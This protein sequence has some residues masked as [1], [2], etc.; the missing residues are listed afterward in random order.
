MNCYSDR[1]ACLIFFLIL[2]CSA[3]TFAQDTTCKAKL[4]AN[5][6][7]SV[8]CNYL[9]I[10][11]NVGGLYKSI[12]GQA[13]NAICYYSMDAQTSHYNR[14]QK[15]EIASQF[16]GAIITSIT[17]PLQRPGLVQYKNEHGD[18]LIDS[19]GPEKI[20]GSYSDLFGAYGW[21]GIVWTKNI[22][23]HTIIYYYSKSSKNSTA[24]DC[25][26]SLLI[27]YHFDGT[28]A[29]RKW[30]STYNAVKPFK[31]ET[32][33][34]LGRISSLATHDSTLLYK[35]GVLQ[36]FGKDTF[37]LQNYLVHE[38]KEYYPTG[39]LKS[40]KYLQSYWNGSN[41]K[42]DT[43]QCLTWRFYNEDGTL[44]KEEKQQYPLVGI[45]IPTEEASAPPD[46]IFLS[47][48]QECAFPGGKKAL[49]R[50]VT[51]NCK[52]ALCNS[53]Q[54]IGGIYT[55][56]L[57]IDKTGYP[58]LISI[59]GL[60]S[61]TISDGVL[62]KMPQWQPSKFNGQPTISTV[63]IKIAIEKNKVTK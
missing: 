9:G 11:K 4:S 53:T 50:F 18:D 27:Q 61:K 22:T 60:N 15:I 3:F 30:F 43:F 34:S 16:D 51:D 42:E 37:F 14:L 2:F 6:N 24:N 25:Q 1:K 12:N 54:E 38:Q 58:Q 13:I 39:I 56:K 23:K 40:L 63:V 57:E 10:C 52:Y 21:S 17:N 29:M 33:D 46:K 44:Q 35:N 45:A 8:A 49:E 59:D 47:V 36:Y 5:R 41:Q 20:W 55:V 7:K 31:T 28:I 26:D 48:E 32:F 62:L 19:L